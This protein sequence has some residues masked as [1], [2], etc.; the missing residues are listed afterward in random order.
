M[1]ELFDE[2]ME[3]TGRNGPNQPHN[4]RADAFVQGA[5]RLIRRKEFFDF[6]S[7]DNPPEGYDDDETPPE[8]YDEDETPPEGY[9]DE[10]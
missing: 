2:L 8:G 3:F 4:D 5:R 1:P 9:G 6:T 10:D 7:K